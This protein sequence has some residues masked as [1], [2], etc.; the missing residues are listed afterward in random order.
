LLL[1]LC[2]FIACPFFLHKL[3]ILPLEL[4]VAI[5]NFDLFT[6]LG[7]VAD[8][9]PPFL[10]EP[11]EVLLNVAAG[12]NPEVEVLAGLVLSDPLE[13]L[14]LN[15][16]QQIYSSIGVESEVGFLLPELDCD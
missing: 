3:G 6:E 16:P 4:F 10:V 9:V 1:L 15:T 7:F 12:E 11:P 14:Y 13:L 2:L 8:Q 5:L